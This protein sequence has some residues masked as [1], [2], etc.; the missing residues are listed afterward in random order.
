M[1]VKQIPN[2]EINKTL[3]T[4]M[5]VRRRSARKSR[6]ERIKN[7][8]RKEIMG[9]KGTP[10]IIETKRLQWYG[11]VERMPMERIW[12]GYHGRAGKQDVEEKRGWKEYK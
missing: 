11:H 6:A 9:V 4:E 3:S 12:N 2:R 1:L 5:F 8:H 10:D 7:E